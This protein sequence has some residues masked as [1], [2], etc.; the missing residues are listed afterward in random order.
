[1]GGFS[2]Q[3]YFNFIP[4]DY[5]AEAAAQCSYS[6][7]SVDDFMA[8]VSGQQS[9]VQSKEIEHESNND[10]DEFPKPEPIS[11]E[12]LKKEHKHLSLLEFYV[13]VVIEMDVDS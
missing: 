12:A 6:Q 8:R 5:A 2:P 10:D 13:P 9:V 11:F 1:M 4:K 3:Y 7:M